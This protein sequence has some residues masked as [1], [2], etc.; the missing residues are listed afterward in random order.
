MSILTHI[1]NR[2][3]LTHIFVIIHQLKYHRLHCPLCLL[4][5]HEIVIVPYIF[6]YYSSQSYEVVCLHTNEIIVKKWH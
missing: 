3:T 2:I 4:Q 6:Y 5:H 1:N